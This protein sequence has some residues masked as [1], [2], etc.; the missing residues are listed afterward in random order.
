MP[1]L[2]DVEC[3]PDGDAWGCR[4]RLTDERGT[5]E[6]NVRVDRVDLERLAPGAIEPEDLVRRSFEFLLEREPRT[7]ILHEFDLPMIGQYFPDYER[8][9]RIHPA[10]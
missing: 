4:V 6:H 8:E 2:I 10:R 7:S 9:I 1:G 5:S 3:R